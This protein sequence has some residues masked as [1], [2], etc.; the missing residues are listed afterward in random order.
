MK[1]SSCTL[2]PDYSVHKTLKTSR[3]VQAKQAAISILTRRYLYLR[4]PTTVDKKVITCSRH[5]MLPGIRQRNHPLHHFYQFVITFIQ[6]FLCWLIIAHKIKR[7]FRFPKL[8]LMI[9]SGKDNQYDS[10]RQLIL[11]LSDKSGKIKQLNFA[12]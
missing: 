8:T 6:F 10:Y 5:N 3:K 1:Y 12:T 11:Q 7:L 4:E 2:V 9:H